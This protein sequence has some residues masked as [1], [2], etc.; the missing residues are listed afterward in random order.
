[1]VRFLEVAPRIGMGSPVHPE[2]DRS[3]VMEGVHG[4]ALGRCQILWPMQRN[5]RQL[6]AKLKGLH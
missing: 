2:E 4:N 3:T 6:T 1:M 5:A